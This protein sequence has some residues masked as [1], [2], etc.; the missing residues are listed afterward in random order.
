M[1][2]VDLVAVDLVTSAERGNWV[3]TQVPSVL[4]RADLSTASSPAGAAIEAM[5]APAGGPNYAKLAEGGAELRAFLRLL[6]EVSVVHSA[7]FFLQVDGLEPEIFAEGPA[8]LMVLVRFGASS[9]TIATKPYQNVL[10]GPAPDAGK[11]IFSTLASDAQGT[12]VPSYS[13]TYAGGSVG[14][15]ISWP[16]APVEADAAGTDFLRAL[17]QLV[18]YKVTAINGMPATQNWSRPGDRHGHRNG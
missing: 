6:W 18:S 2:R 11:A 17:Y 14:W 9:G 4:V 12:P 3:S 10:V 5:A 13:A 7:G 8:N 1:G 15:S 16:D